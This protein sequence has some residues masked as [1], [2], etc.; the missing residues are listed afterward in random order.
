MSGRRVVVTP[1]LV[2]LGT[3]QRAANTHLGEQVAKSG[4]LLVAVGR[5][6]RAALVQGA[7]SHGGEVLT[8]ARR[9]AAREWVRANL[10]TGDGVLWEND[11][12]DT[13]P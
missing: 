4:A 12:P 5:T 11:L 3:A 7:R 13:Y 2:E 6:N 8:V 10:G 1:G 9:P